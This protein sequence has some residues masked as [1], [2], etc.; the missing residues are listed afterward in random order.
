MLVAGAT[1]PEELGEI[2]RLVGDMPLLVPGVGA[3]GGDLQAVLTEGA[4][5]QGRGLV[6]NASR[7]I[8]YADPENPAR[9]A[10]QAAAELCAEISRLQAELVQVAHPNPQNPVPGA[11]KQV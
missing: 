2:R 6:I 5:S 3:Q 4:D 8:L 11:A 7:T 10:A 9:G 1:Y